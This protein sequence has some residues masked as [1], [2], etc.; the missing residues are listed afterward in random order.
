MSREE[1]LQSLIEQCDTFGVDVDLTTIDEDIQVEVLE[2]LLHVQRMNMTGYSYLAY[3]P[4]D[5][6]MAYFRAAGATSL[7]SYNTNYIVL[8]FSAL[9][10]FGQEY[11]IPEFVGILDNVMNEAVANHKNEL[12]RDKM[13]P[14]TKMV[15]MIDLLIVGEEGK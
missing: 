12:D 7:A 13:H 10:D 3:L 4:D 2:V 14:I 5:I 15:L 11:S 9:Q 6:N 8:L 1:R